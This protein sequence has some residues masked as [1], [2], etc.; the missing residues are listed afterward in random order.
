M[1]SI[2]D[3]DGITPAGYHLELLPGWDGAK[4]DQPQLGQGLGR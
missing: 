3:L 2:P 4:S 1:Q